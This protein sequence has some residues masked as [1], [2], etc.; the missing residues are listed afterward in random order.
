VSTRTNIEWTRGQD[1]SAGRSWNP[2]TGCDKVSEGCGLPRFAGDKSGGCYAEAIA[3]RFA[4]SKAF[5]HGFALTLRPQRL[6]DPL[7]WREPARMFVNSMSDLYHQQVPDEYIAR[8]FAVMALSPQHQYIVLTKRHARM[9]V[10]LSGR[11]G[12]D[13][14]E[15]ITEVIE[16]DYDLGETGRLAVP[17][18]LPNLVCGV[19]AETQ[20]WARARV[21]ALL[22]TPAAVRM[23]S[24]EPLLS[25]IDLRTLTRPGRSIDALTGDVKTSSGEVYAAAPGAIDWVIAGAESGPGA[26]PMAPEWVR[27]LRDQ[28]VATGTAFFYKQDADTR[29]R[30]I[31]T[32][33]LDGQR[34]TEQPAMAAR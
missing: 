4:G 29:G 22:E 14:H 1:G 27:S 15:A 17:W 11:G 7:S 12:F 13:L 25:P 19:S 31:P 3:R 33:E 24:A 28:C 10:L 8:I 30:K 2:V 26:R 34:W 6:A 16:Q 21:P 9:R 32:P 5:P 23:V 20:A 18:P